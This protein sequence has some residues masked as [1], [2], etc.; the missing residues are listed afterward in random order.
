MCPK[1]FRGIAK[2]AERLICIQAFELEPYHPLGI[3]KS[4]SLGREPLTYCLEKN[5]SIPVKKGLSRFLF[6]GIIMANNTVCDSTIHDKKRAFRG[7]T[8]YFYLIYVK[9]KKIFSI[10][11]GK[12]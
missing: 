1:H 10:Q 6:Y 9:I 2:L 11:G 7:K 3:S 5:D 12:V 4:E 8:H